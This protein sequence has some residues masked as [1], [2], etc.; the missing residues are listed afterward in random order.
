MFIIIIT[1]QTSSYSYSRENMS[2]KLL[3]WDLIMRR[4]VTEPGKKKPLHSIG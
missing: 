3:R 4:V 1:S 2:L